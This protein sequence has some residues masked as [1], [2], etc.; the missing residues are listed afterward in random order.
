MGYLPVRNTPVHITLTVINAV[1]GPTIPLLL[2]ETSNVILDHIT[3]DG[4]SAAIPQGGFTWEI[5]EG[6]A[7]VFF[8]TWNTNI[9]QQMTWKVLLYALSAIWEGSSHGGFGTLMFTIYNDG[10]EVGR[11]TV[12]P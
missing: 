11:G 12:G 6:N 4:N 2:M 10:T 1:F 9:N 3:R 5:R 7:R 8:R